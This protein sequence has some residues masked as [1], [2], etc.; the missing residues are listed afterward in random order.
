VGVGLRAEKYLTDPPALPP[1]LVD[2]DLPFSGCQLAD[3]H[4]VRT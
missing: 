4:V 2:V 1:V 3:A